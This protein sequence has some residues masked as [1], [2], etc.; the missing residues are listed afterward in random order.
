[1]TPL[2]PTKSLQRAGSLWYMACESLAVIDK[3]RILNLDEPPAAELRRQAT[4]GV[5][6]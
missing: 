4:G 5:S 2:S 3:V 6:L 1:M